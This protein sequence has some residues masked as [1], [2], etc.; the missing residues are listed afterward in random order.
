[1]CPLK[2]VNVLELNKDIL[3]FVFQ[4][5][6]KFLPGMLKRDDG[7]IVVISDV[8]SLT[9]IQNGAAYTAS[10]WGVNGRLF[11]KLTFLHIV[12]H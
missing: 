6:R 2:S 1:M 10:K 7:H 8:L 12:L 3:G 5:I 9:A 4:L 11:A